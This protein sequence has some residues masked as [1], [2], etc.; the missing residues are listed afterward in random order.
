MWKLISPNLD[1][2]KFTFYRIHIINIYIGHELI[3]V[4]HLYKKI[5]LNWFHFTLINIMFSSITVMKLWQLWLF[6]SI[7]LL[8]VFWWLWILWS[9]LGVPYSVP[10]TTFLWNCLCKS[11]VYDLCYSQPPYMF[12]NESLMIQISFSAKPVP[13]EDQIVWTIKPLHHLYQNDSRETVIDN[14]NEETDLFRGYPI[15]VKSKTSL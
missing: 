8:S 12:H 14:E 2:L 15:K 7:L 1:K 6:L 13:Q 10:K 4:Q 9:N 11:F 5:L 3:K